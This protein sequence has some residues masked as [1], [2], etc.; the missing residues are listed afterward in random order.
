MTPNQAFEDYVYHS[1][2]YYGMDTQEISD[3]SFDA[4]CSNLL[5]DWDQVTH[6]DR[7]RLTDPTALQ[8]GTGFQMQNKWPYWAIDRAKR[9][10][11]EHW[12][13]NQAV[14]GTVIPAQ[15]I[16]S[17]PEL[18]IRPQLQ[19]QSA[20]TGV[21]SR[22]APADVL[23]IMRRVGKVQC[24][25][26][27]VL[28]SG[29]APG[30]DD[31]FHLGAMESE[32][33]CGQSVEIYL[34]WG[35]FKREGLPT[36]YHEPNKGIYDASRFENWAEAE[37]IS[38]KARGSWNGLG[39]GGIKLHTRNAYQPLG[40]DLKSKS[41]AVVGYAKVVGKNKWSGGTNTAFQI[42]TTY[43]IPIYNLYVES[44]RNAIEAFL[45]KH[46]AK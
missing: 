31:E 37:A 5:R 13:L 19:W 35:S 26:G 22:E 23:A 10:G 25:R 33:F 34:P 21:G 16:D 14:R 41:K 29:G 2:L 36:L 43:G 3:H 32:N 7:D 30:P 11:H 24:D 38:L 4:L 44:Q 39:Q 40:R 18:V 15:V 42:A 17:E 20:Y 6:P 27:L 12:V 45:A 28:R 9:N 1:L 8:A 46:E